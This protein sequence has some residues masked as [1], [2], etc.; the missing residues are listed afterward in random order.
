M[1]YLRASL[2]AFKCCYKLRS[3]CLLLVLFVKMNGAL[4][5][6]RFKMRVRGP[7]R[8]LRRRIYRTKKRPNN[9]GS[10][11]G[12]KKSRERAKGLVWANLGTFTDYLRT[13]RYNSVFMLIS[14]S[15]NFTLHLFL[16]RYCIMS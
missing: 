10:S 16:L 11:L 3:E 14:S 7:S 4:W 1:Q 13:F 8:P 9:A 15:F 2:R 6:K 5:A 12:S